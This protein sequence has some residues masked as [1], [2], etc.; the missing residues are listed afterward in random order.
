MIATLALAVATV[1]GAWSRPAA[2]TGVVYATVA[3]AGARTIALVGAA[4]PVA[5]SAE[6]HE[7]TTMKGG[8]MAGMAM[9]AMAMHPVARIIVPP[10]GSVA[11]HPGGYHVMLLGLRRPLKAGTRFPVTFRF[12][13]G[14][15]VTVL[16]PVEDRAM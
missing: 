3:N 5:R 16:V 1:A 10:H 9:P 15:R 7:S 14:E 4:S 2:D 6:L 12:S 13:D 11:L 8:T